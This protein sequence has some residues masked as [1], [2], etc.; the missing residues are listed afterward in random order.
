VPD[1]LVA[2]D[3]A[4]S[5]RDP[6]D[7]GALVIG[8]RREREGKAVWERH[9]YVQ[10]AEAGGDTQAGGATPFVLRVIDVQL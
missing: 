9:Q 10:S 1:D 3:G 8:E 6:R 4:D 2:C 7:V 5:G